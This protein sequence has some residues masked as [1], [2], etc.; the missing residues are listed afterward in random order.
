MEAYYD[1][2]PRQAAGLCHW[3]RVFGRIP[4][5]AMVMCVRSFLT[6]ADRTPKVFGLVSKRWITWSG[7]WGPMQWTCVWNS[8]RISRIA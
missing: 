1:R 3:Q 4:W 8:P 2:L 6:D 5:K 7:L